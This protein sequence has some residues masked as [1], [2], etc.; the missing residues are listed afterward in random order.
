MLRALFDGTDPGANLNPG[1]IVA[2]GRDRA[3]GETLPRG[4]RSR[5]NG[6]TGGPRRS[7]DAQ[8]PSQPRT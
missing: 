7:L 4:E 2:T 6:G 5:T 1:K 8:R 3:P